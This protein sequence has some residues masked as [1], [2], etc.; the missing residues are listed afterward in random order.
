MGIPIRGKTV[1][2]L[3]IGSDFLLS[4]WPTGWQT[5][6]PFRQTL[7]QQETNQPTNLPTS[8]PTVLTPG[9]KVEYKR[10][11]QRRSARDAFIDIM[12]LNVASW[13]FLTQSDE[14]RATL[15][16]NR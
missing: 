8:Q 2:I 14:R 11:G 3:E 16:C 1:F 7:S 10:L 4:E 13:A 15:P 6:K 12:R 5:Y 9:P